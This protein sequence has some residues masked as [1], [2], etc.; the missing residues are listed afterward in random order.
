MLLPTVRLERCLLWIGS[1]VLVYLCTVFPSIAASGLSPAEE[2][3]I[4]QVYAGKSFTWDQSVSN[5]AIATNW[6]SQNSNVVTVLDYN[7][8]TNVVWTMSTNFSAS[9]TGNVLYLTYQS[10]SFATVYPDQGIWGLDF[11]NNLTPLPFV[12]VM[13]AGCWKVS[14]DGSVTSTTNEYP[15]LFWVVDN[16]GAVSP[17]S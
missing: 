6:I 2:A 3:F 5:S 16:V 17:R 9:A 8:F 15:D 13:T 10:N 11:Q 1:L 12:S 7:A 4:R 14:T